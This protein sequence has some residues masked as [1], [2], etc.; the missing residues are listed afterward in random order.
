MTT[1]TTKQELDELRESAH[2]N[3]IRLQEAASLL[4]VELEKTSSDT[5]TQ[6]RNQTP[7]SLSNETMDK[8]KE[9]QLLYKKTFPSLK[10]FMEHMKIEHSEAFTT[11]PMTQFL[12]TA[13]RLLEDLPYCLIHA[14]KPIEQ[15]IHGCHQLIEELQ[16]DVLQIKEQQ[17][18][19]QNKIHWSIF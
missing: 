12:H 11:E 13:E 16:R 18:T 8:A 10:K 19:A 7:V 14:P 4:I 2:K 17:L 15:V 1:T 9:L 3:L 5:F 6:K